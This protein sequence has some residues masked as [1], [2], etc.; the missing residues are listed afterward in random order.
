MTVQEFA[1]KNGMRFLSKGEINQEITGCYI[2]DLLS[3]AMSRVELGNAWLTVQ[4]NV[5]VVG[6][7]ALTEP[8]CIILVDDRVLDENAAEKA[9]E[10]GV[11][12]L[13]T[14]LSAYEIACRLF[15]QSK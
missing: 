1:E 7:A 5:N 14:E 9:K 12:V 6:V 10:Q 4:G 13:S 2:G 15:E 11:T 8:S 3:L